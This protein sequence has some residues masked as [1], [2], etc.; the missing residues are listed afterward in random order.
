MAGDAVNDFFDL[1][2]LQKKE[3]LRVAGVWKA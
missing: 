2:S 3:F 1:L